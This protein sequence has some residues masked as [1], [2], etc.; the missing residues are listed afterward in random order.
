MIS[1][2]TYEEFLLPYDIYLSERLQ[3][4]GIHHCGDNMEHVKEGFAKVEKCEFFDV[5]WGS[6]VAECREALPDAWFNIRLSPVKL[7][8]DTKQEVKCD[9]ETLILQ[10]APLEKVGVCCINM[11]AGIPDENIRAIFEVVKQYRRYGA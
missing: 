3:P 6:N 2:E 8:T 7:M 10:A 9:V 11:D 5:G 4:Y 1:N